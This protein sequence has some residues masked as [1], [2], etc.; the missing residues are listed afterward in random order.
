MAE[1]ET[2]TETEEAKIKANVIRSKARYCQEGQ[3]KGKEDA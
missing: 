3:G 2:E 1:A